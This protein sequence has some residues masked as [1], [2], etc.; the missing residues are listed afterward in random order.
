MKPIAD[1]PDDLMIPDELGATHHAVC[2]AAA[3]IVPERAFLAALDAR[4]QRECTS[5]AAVPA[6]FTFPAHEA[7]NRGEMIL[8]RMRGHADARATAGRGSTITRRSLLIGSV[9]AT[10]AA[11]VAALQR[12]QGTVVNIP[13][14][15][16][17]RNLFVTAQMVAAA[18]PVVTAS[19]V[20]QPSNL[21]FAD[22]LVGW[23]LWGSH[24]DDYD[25]GIDPHVMQHGAG[26]AYLRA[27]VPDPSG[28]G[29][30]MRSFVPNAYRGT[31]VRMTGTVKA[32]AVE[33][34]AGLWMRVDG[35]N[36]QELSFDNMAG[37][38][39]TGT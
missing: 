39:I 13:A 2:L 23:G 3:A 36:N 25:D 17:A 20:G 24:P 12:R 8:D 28:F 26:S 16:Q 34:W 22:G 7:A 33:N 37:R 18:P 11:A 19:T 21:D 10:A 32:D 30:L 14:T 29:T 15:Q 4:V 5:D 6:A 27:K 38:P 35:P 9:A 1:L 31:R